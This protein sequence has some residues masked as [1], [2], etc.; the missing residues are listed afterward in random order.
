M[1]RF[2]TDCGDALRAEQERIE[3]IARIRYPRMKL[4][5]MYFWEIGYEAAVTAG[6]DPDLS[7]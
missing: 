5:D 7:E 1:V 2:C 3:K 6:G 4:V